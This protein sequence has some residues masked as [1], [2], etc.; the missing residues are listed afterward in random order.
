VKKRLWLW[1]GAAVC[2]LIVIM[3][4]FAACSD[5]SQTPPAIKSNQPTPTSPPNTPISSLLSQVIPARTGGSMAYDAK[6]KQT[7]LFSGDSQDDTWAWDGQSWSQLYPA[8]TP[9][10]RNNASMAYDAATGQL[11]LFGGVGVTGTAFSDTWAWDGT[12]WALLNPQIVPPARSNASL[13]YDA[14]HKKLVLFGGLVAGVQHASPN[15]GDTWTWDGTNWHQEHPQTSPST[16]SQASMTYDAAHQQVV[17]F[18]GVAAKSVLNDTWTWDG[19]N[20][21]QIQ[22]S[23]QPLARADANLVYD[24]AHQQVLLFGGVGASSNALNDTWAW[25]GLSWS[26]QKAQGPAGGN[27]IATYDANHQNIVAYA[28][29][30]VNRIAVSG[31]TWLWN[32]SSWSIAKQ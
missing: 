5:M 19:T 6:T 24:A 28:A 20:W 9:P 32:G 12:N 26:E 21:H 31:Q 1:K 2:S 25:N 22:S 16:R 17:L 29:Q 8:T 13:T 27:T 7:I 10:V 30:I 14:A 15:T 4:L 23:T 11:I 3:S 18:G